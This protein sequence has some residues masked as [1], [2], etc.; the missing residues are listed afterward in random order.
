MSDAQSSGSNNKAV[1]YTSII[2]GGIFFLLG[3]ILLL[4][5]F[6]EGFKTTLNDYSL[7]KYFTFGICDG[8]ELGMGYV[9]VFVI[10]LLLGVAGVGY[11][12]HTLTK[13]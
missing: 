4:A 12:V 13:A 7:I 9:G 11:G 1:T 10:Y 2:L 6:M 5:Y 8:A 3:L